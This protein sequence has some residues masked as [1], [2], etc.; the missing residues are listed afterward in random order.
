MQRSSRDETYKLIEEAKKGN[1]AAKE[2]LVM[3]NTGLVSM[4][5]RRFATSAYELDDMMQLGYIGL[6]K[7]IDRFDIKFGVMFSTY[8][9]PMIAG[10]IRRFLR[11]D[12]R[13]KVSRQLK[14]DIKLLKDAEEEF[15]QKY[16]RSPRISE[17]A[18]AMKCTREEISEM[19]E[20][21]TAITS[22]ASLDDESFIS[23]CVNEPVSDD[24]AD[25]ESRRVEV[26]DMRDMLMSLSEKE[27]N[28]II[29]RYF[30]D[31]TQQQTGDRL[32]ISQVQVSRLEKRALDGMRE[33]ARL[34]I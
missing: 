10:E 12:C 5:A 28:I 24:R 13:V 4:T 33:H 15:A 17:L 18:E 26:M 20:A 27:R 6:I 8:A 31:M 29:M 1:K 16:G 3:E 22:T 30:R 2:R 9:V 23:S 32:G 19:L 25:D 34:N 7:A 21:R 11:D 14:Q